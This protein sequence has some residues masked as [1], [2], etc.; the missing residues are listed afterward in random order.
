MVTRGFFSGRRPASDTDARIAPGQYLEQGFPVLSAARRY[1]RGSNAF[2]SA[3]AEALIDAG[4]PTGLIRTERYGC[5]RA[6]FLLTGEKVAQT[7]LRPELP[8][9]FDLWLATFRNRPGESKML[10]GIEK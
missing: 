2:V 5:E 6:R 7:R 3:A 9:P 1:V 4:I 10:S 8:T